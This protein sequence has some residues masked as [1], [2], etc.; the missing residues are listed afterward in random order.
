MA[1][2]G[3]PSW[4][5]V[6]RIQDDTM[7]ID[8]TSLTAIDTHVHLEAAPV[9]RRRM[10][11][12]RSISATA[13]SA[14]TARRSPTTTA[15]ARSAASCSPSTSGSPA[16]RRSRTTTSLAFAPA[17]R[18]HRD[19]VRQRRSDPRAGGHPRG[20]AADRAG[21]VRGLKLHPPLQQFF[22]NDRI[23]YPLYEL[24]AEAGLPVLFHTGHSG[25]GTGVPGGGGIRLKYGHPDADRRRRGRFPEHADHHGAPVVPLAGRGD[26][27]LPAQAD[28]S[29]SIS[30]A[31]RRS[32][33]RRRWSSTRTRLLKHKVLFG[34]D[35]P[36]ITP[37]RWLADF[38]KIGIKTRCGR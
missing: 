38:D 25:I 24:F 12:R 17:N 33:S 23:A 1:H 30:R 3:R 11:P 32:I 10:P 15:R 18:R 31:G 29:T 22:P 21:L 27:D 37:D 13:A 35:Y 36:W 7:T 34:S 2:P 20:A 5:S 9:V 8:T 6:Q 14:A 4:S 28:R 16:G 19:A 26:L